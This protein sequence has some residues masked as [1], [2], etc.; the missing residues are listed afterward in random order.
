[1]QDILHWYNQGIIQP[2]VDSIYA[3]EDVRLEL[4]ITKKRIC[5][6]QLKIL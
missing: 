5:N 1:M 4:D 6:L 3:L 2:K